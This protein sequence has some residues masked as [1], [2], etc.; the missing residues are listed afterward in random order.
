MKLPLPDI[1]GKPIT[2]IADLS[3]TLDTLRDVETPTDAINLIFASGLL[4]EFSQ[5]PLLVL[6]AVLNDNTA[7]FENYNACTLLHVVNSDASNVDLTQTDIS[8]LSFIS[9][10]VFLICV[11]KIDNEYHLWKYSVQRSKCSLIKQDK[12]VIEWLNQ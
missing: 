10:D 4:V 12:Y 11:K 3:F 8:W 6:T 5:C 9:K 1:P 2:F 7:V